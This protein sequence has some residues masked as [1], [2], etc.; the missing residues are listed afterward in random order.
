MTWSR[1]RLTQRAQLGISK[2]WQKLL[3]STAARKSSTTVVKSPSVRS[4]P[5]RWTIAKSLIVVRDRLRPRFSLIQAFHWKLNRCNQKHHQK[6]L[7][8]RAKHVPSRQ[9]RRFFASTLKTLRASHRPSLRLAPRIWT[10]VS[11]C[12]QKTKRDW[13]V[14]VDAES[15]ILP[16]VMKVQLAVASIALAHITSE[17][18]RAV[19]SGANCTRLF[20]LQEQASSFSLSLPISSP[21]LKRF[22]LVSSAFPT[23]RASAFSRNF[24]LTILNESQLMDGKLLN[25]KLRDSCRRKLL[26]LLQNA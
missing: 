10:R 5:S 7:Q 6:Q 8:S 24:F 21:L 18:F 23:H 15:W 20:T 2:V 26:C 4:T 22:P 25:W 16:K 9:Q 12:S 13:Q 17:E 1:E 3:S 11:W 14:S 19:G